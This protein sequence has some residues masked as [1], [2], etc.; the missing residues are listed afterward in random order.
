MRL[1]LAVFD[2]LFGNFMT[3]QD[4]FWLPFKNVQLVKHLYCER[5]ANT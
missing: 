4:A 3:R 2:V 5:T 1:L